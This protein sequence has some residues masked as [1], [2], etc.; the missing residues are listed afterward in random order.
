MISKVTLNI[1]K[2]DMEMNILFA[3]LEEMDLFDALQQV[4]AVWM[5]IS[6]LPVAL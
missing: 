4:R 6:R 3:P 1:W 5:N 2:T